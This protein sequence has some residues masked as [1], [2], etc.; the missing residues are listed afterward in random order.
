MTK[1]EVAFAMLGGTI[2]AIF[3][4]A[5]NIY[6]NYS[7]EQLRPNPEPTRTSLPTRTI[8]PTRTCPALQYKMLPDGEGVE[9]G[10]TVAYE[11]LGLAQSIILHKISSTPG[12]Y[13]PDLSSASLW[14]NS[15]ALEINTAH[16]KIVSW[17][18]LGFLTC[19]P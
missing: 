11:Y 1:R 18:Q 6:E 2:T 10:L 9:D 14:L 4:T 7:L 3:L 5:L 19:P 17:I 15:A 16:A 8:V 12:L 13:D